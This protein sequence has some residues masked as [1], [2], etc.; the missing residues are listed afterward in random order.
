M[1]YNSTG[2]D[3]VDCS[4]NPTGQCSINVTAYAFMWNDRKQFLT[5]AENWNPPTTRTCA[6]SLRMILRNQP[7]KQVYSF[8]K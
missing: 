1:N 7:P 8:V 3:E 4:L 5:L 2:G 6:A